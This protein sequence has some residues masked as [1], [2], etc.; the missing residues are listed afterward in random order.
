MSIAQVEGSGTASVSPAAVAP[1]AKPESATA[2]K[3]AAAAVPAGG[4]AWIIADDG[5]AGPSDDVEVG[6]VG[7][8]GQGRQPIVADIAVDAVVTGDTLRE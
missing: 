4:R 8:P 1:K 7:G 3:R 6:D 2:T 5:V